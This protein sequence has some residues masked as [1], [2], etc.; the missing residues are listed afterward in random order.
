MT[1]RGDRRVMRWILIAAGA[2]AVG[3]GLLW[4]ALQ[5]LLATNPSR[6]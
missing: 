5:L 6:K 2:S 1:A 4:F 3:L